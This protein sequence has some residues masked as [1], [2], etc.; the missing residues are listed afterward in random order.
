M[1]TL[2]RNQIMQHLIDEELLAEA[3][4]GFVGGRSCVTQLIE[5][6]EEWTQILDSG[7][8]VDAIYL[9]FRKAFDTVAHQRL[10]TK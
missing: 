10:L 5:T 8:P 7:S 3:Q 9:D 4:H 2:I 1:E 6:I